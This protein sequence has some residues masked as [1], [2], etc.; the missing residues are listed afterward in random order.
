M[1]DEYLVT[2]IFWIN[3]RESIRFRKGIGDPKPWTKDPILQEYRFCN[4]Q[5]ENDT[6][7]QWINEYWRKPY[8]DHPNLWFAMCLSR[9]I[10]W[11]E[12][13]SDIGFPTVWDAQQTRAA[14]LARQAKGQKAYTG[15]FMLRGS[16]QKSM[17]KAQYITDNMTEL[18]NAQDKP[19]PTDTLESYHTRLMSYP[20]WGSFLAAQAVADLKHTK[21]LSHATDWWDWCAIGPGSMKGLNYLHDRPLTAQIKQADFVKEVAELRDKIVP[22]IVEDGFYGTKPLKLCLQDVQNC[23]CEFSKYMKTKQGAGRPR[24]RYKGV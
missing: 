11:P 21:W 13:L 7:T 9:Q 24:T 4:V 5:R 12:T 6:V 3:E 23:L 16:I 2:L 1:R 20:G 15:A 17:D 8:A 10:N 19:L 14:I 18:F 22:Y